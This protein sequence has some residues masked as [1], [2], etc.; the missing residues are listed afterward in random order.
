MKKITLISISLL[1]LISFS[2]IY[3]QQ[4]LDVKILNGPIKID[5]VLDKQWFE[6]KST[7]NFTQLEPNKGA[8]SSRKTI[9][10]IAQF[11]E[12]LYISFQCFVKDKKEIA[13]RIQRR[14][15]LD[16]SDDIIAVL[17]DTYNDKR[18]SQLFFVNPIGTLT[19]AKVT[20]D[21]KNVDLLWDTEWEAKTSVTDNY[22][23]VEIVIPLKS[24]QHDPNSNVWG[25]NFG[26]IIRS[27]QETAWWIPVSEDF[28]ISQSGSLIGIQP[29]SEKKHNLT[30][31]PYATLR[32]E[33]SDITGIHD[34]IKAEA[35]GDIKYQ[36]RSNIVANLTINPDFA[37][38]E[39]DKEQINLTPWELRFPEKRIFFQDGNE[40]FG[41]RISTFYSRRIGDM[42]YGG[43]MIGKSGKY[44][45]NALSART[46][47]NEILNDPESW[48][49]AFRVKRDF[50][51]S[52]TLGFTYADKI[53][54]TSYVRS[55]SAD[56]VLNLGKTW[57]LTGQ[58]VTSAPGDFKSHSAW[59][60]RF[61]KENNL[62]HYHVR[63]SN[64][65]SNFQDNVNQTGFI[66]DDDRH[67]I[68]SDITY[69][70]WFND[71]IKYLYL[72]GY[73]NIF[74]SQEGDLRSWYLTYK[75]RAYFEN[76]FSLNAY[77]N[78]EYKLLDKDY[79][80]HYYR[81]ELGYNTDESVF[82]NTAF[83][84]GRNFDR[85]FNLWQINTRFQLFKKL[86]LTYEFNHLKYSPDPTSKSTTINVLGA[87]Y[88]FNKNIWL[89]VFTQKNSLADKFYFYGLVGW[90]FKPPFG[91]AYLIVNTNEF[92]DVLT[93][94]HFQSQI[95]FLKLTYPI[96][97]F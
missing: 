50:L 21:G 42:Q 67:E 1:I 81:A 23:V 88:F 84:T 82:I 79:Y 61:A 54:D 28:R 63:Y 6:T 78:N 19:D 93:R 25:A 10:R 59:F 70:F 76:R 3:S 56:Y 97:V 30:I 20:D 7:E 18:T 77:Y 16:K 92:D 12:N 36:Y 94:E 73:N 26:R 75:A 34:K 49:N 90:R 8:E 86:T 40:M 9:V 4:S 62:Y 39:G 14:D 29:E 47:E 66:Q 45:F 13:A 38:V 51:K 22:W 64:I 44:Q 96:S 5:G 74:W 85:D 65:G 15:Q 41:T 57:K 46:E 31:F 87:D 37:T 91:A 80:N 48:F 2:K 33:N 17:L 58:F 43:K 68:D 69:K 35:G 71:K 72:A 95:V 55:Y 83:R 32:Y 24:I 89:R 27:N 53:T 11:K 52:S 60:V